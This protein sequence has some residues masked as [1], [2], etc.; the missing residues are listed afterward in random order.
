MITNRIRQFWQFLTRFLFSNNSGNFRCSMMDAD[1]S[2]KQEHTVEAHLISVVFSV[3]SLALYRAMQAVC[4][5]LLE[6][7]FVSSWSLRVAIVSRPWRGTRWGHC[8]A[9]DPVFN[10]HDVPLRV[11]EAAQRIGE[12]CCVLVTP[13]SVQTVPLCS[14]DFLFRVWLRD[15]CALLPIFCELRLAFKFAVVAP[16]ACLVTTMRNAGLLSISRFLAFYTLF[17]FNPSADD[18]GQP[19]NPGPVVSDDGTLCPCRP[20]GKTHTHSESLPAR[21]KSVKWHNS[22]KTQ[23]IITGES[24][25]DA[26]LAESRDRPD[27]T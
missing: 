17:H 8:L 1:L 25:A 4:G 22:V 14:L 7:D 10:M 24:K 12:S 6:Q 23:Y 27:S 26:R 20:S 16:C 3:P 5:I 21:L 9:L 18:D 19:P 11:I 2:T 13:R 15:S